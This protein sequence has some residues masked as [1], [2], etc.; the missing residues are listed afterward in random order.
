MKKKIEKDKEY[1]YIGRA[2]DL[3]V[4]N[5]GSSGG[6]VRAL[7]IFLLEK[8]E[9]EGALVTFLDGLK[10]KQ[11]IVTTPEEILNSARSIYQKF[12]FTPSLEKIKNSNL[13]R[14]AVVG[15]PCQISV[16]KKALG[17]YNKK[18]IYLSLFCGRNLK[19]EATIALLRKL[20]VKP[21]EVKSLDYRAGKGYGGFTVF[22][23]NNKK[24]FVPKDAYN[25]LN[26]TYIDEG[27]L[28]CRDFYGQFADISFGD[29]WF[30]K[31]YSTIL[32]RGE[33]NLKL[34]LNA[35]NLKL[36]EVDKKIFFKQHKHIVNLKK[37]KLNLSK[38]K[39]LFNTL[40][41]PILLLLTKLGKIYKRYF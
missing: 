25:Y 38:Y 16:Y 26:L 41:F 13:Q 33:E 4:R 39:K 10:P 22:F 17:I 21:S 36:E 34:L 30:K 24:K 11:K 6:A 19:F 28:N 29:C 32:V 31:R 9:I 35:E 7:L 12:D 1:Y 27:C 20:K 2:R 5:R 18:I 23:N 37:S 8:N 3:E 40:P 15:L 14:I